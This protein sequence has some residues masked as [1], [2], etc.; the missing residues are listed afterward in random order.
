MVEEVGCEPAY[1]SVALNQLPMGLL[2]LLA[3]FYSDG[4]EIRRCVS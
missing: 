3:H 2:V 4:Q 1:L